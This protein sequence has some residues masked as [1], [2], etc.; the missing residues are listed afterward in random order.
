MAEENINQE[1][2][3]ETKN[4]F[5]EEIEQNELMS[6]SAKRF[7]RFEIILFSSFLILASAVTRCISVS[8]F[9]SLVGIPIEIASSAIRLKVCART[10]GIKRYKSI[11]KKKKSMHD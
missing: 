1:N 8:A 9:A 6:K 2:R 4:Y 5:I 10:A 11:I 7:T 3:D